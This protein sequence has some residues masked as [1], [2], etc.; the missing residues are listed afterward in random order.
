MSGPNDSSVAGRKDSIFA[1]VP[2]DRRPTE[3][4]MMDDHNMKGMAEKFGN[5][6]E[7][8]D[9]IDGARDAT[10][11]EHSMGMWEAVKLYPKAVG[12]SVLAST[13]LV[14]EVCHLVQTNLRFEAYHVYRA[15]I[16]SLS[17]RF[18]VLMLFRGNMVFLSTMA[19]AIIPSPLLGNLVSVTVPTWEKLL[20]NFPAYTIVEK[21][22]ADCQSKGL[23]C[24][25]ILAER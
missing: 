2:G 18:T 3:V 16:L 21:Q 10:A 12:W 24:A 11:M 8:Q 13:A 4:V 25:G 5:D 23:M 7:L 14:M 6:G 20:V 15:M 22:Q 9:M 19:L 1:Q 17:V